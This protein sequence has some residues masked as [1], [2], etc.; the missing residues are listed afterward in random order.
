[1]DRISRQIANIK[2]N[3]IEVVKSQPSV[4]SL[5]NGQEVIYI[6]RN[7][8][9]ERYRKEQG[10]LWTSY[11]DT[12]NN[13]TV[14][15]N[16]FV[17]NN[18]NV[19]GSITGNQYMMFCHNFADD[20]GTS[21]HYLPWSDQSEST[22]SPG[23]SGTSTT[24]FLTPFKMTLKKIIWR[25]D[26]TSQQADFTFRVYRVDSGDNTTDTVATAEYDATIYADTAQELNRS[27]FDNTPEVP[28]N[29]IAALSI[30]TDADIDQGGL[31]YKHYITSLW[32]VEIAL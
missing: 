14:N 27:D 30:H 11:M 26:I 22:I 3:K 5:R 17:E 18:L 13:Y 1:M 6:S 21:T 12:D 7:N 31:G 24:G 25:N 4:N 8:R 28:A 10:R 9:L 15:K 32:E 19:K 23:G 29:A 20:L 2:Q 16:L